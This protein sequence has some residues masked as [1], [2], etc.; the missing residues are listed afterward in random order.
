M[1]A[2]TRAPLDLAE[3][4]PLA[5]PPGFTDALAAVGAPVSEAMLS[6]LG[7]YLAGLL[8]MNTRMNLTSVREPE[9]AWSR[10]ILDSLTLL[11]QLEGVASGG[12][13][14]DVGSGGGLPAIPIAIAR[15]D[16]HVT[17][18][19]STKKKA[20]FLRAISESLGLSRVRVKGERAE[21]LH[22]SMA[23][24]FDIATARAV[25]RLSQLVPLT[26]PFVKR[27]GRLLLIKGQRAPEELADAAKTLRRARAKHV[28][29]VLSPTGRVV[30][31]QKE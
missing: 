3:V 16:L 4:E 29:T 18:V 28:E 14:I 30:V 5:P 19:E 13:L 10:H 25:A 31:L 6:S 27:G 24:R 1:A 26:A 15:P 7:A 12:H 9:A 2:E 17:M 11:P 21:Q 20:R 22:G 8:A 23:G